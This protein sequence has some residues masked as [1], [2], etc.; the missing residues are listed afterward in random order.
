MNLL[1][2]SFFIGLY[3]CILFF[4]LQLQISNVYLL[5]FAFGFLKHF[6]AFY[7]G[8]HKY[9]CNSG[10]SCKTLFTDSRVA[11]FSP[12]FL[13]SIVEGLFYLTSVFVL[14]GSLNSRLVYIFVMTI[15][16]H[17]VSDKLGIY[18]YYCLKNC[19]Q[20]KPRLEKYIMMV[21]K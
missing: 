1:S 8:I 15:I 17:I 19:V 6:L 5:L 18:K 12:I 2:E 20:K 3:S 4:L 11:S 21:T 7:T 16:S 9:Y 13:Q 10:H 14:P